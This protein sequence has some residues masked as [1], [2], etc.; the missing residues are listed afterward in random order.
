MLVV[1]AFILVV[2]VAAGGVLGWIAA[3]VFFGVCVTS[4]TRERDGYRR[5]LR[6]IRRLCRQRGSN[7]YLGIQVTCNA[8]L[9]DAD[10]PIEPNR[11]VP[12]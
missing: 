10:L 7:S 5:A 4:L 11:M 2:A 3:V 9:G 1:P 8:A 6:D 12:R